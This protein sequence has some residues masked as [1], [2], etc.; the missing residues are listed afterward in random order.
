MSIPQGVYAVYGAAADATQERIRSIVEWRGRCLLNSV[1]NT[2]IGVGCLGIGI[3]FYEYANPLSQLMLSG[4]MIAPVVGGVSIC[5]LVGGVCLY[6]SSPPKFQ[7]LVRELKKATDRLASENEKLKSNVKDFQEKVEAFDKAS[8]ATQKT[9]RVFEDKLDATNSRM[10]G[11]VEGLI[12]VEGKMQT[13]TLSTKDAEENLKQ[14][15]DRLADLLTDVS[16]N[17]VQESSITHQ[18]DQTV[19]DF[20]NF[21]EKS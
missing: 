18:E 6:A 17:P 15:V 14:Q 20:Y 11:A 5:V 21:L 9:Y 13:A 3:G 4:W 1:R 16:S 19:I 7:E 10:S 2:L 12:K 8:Q